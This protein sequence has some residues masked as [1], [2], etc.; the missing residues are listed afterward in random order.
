MTRRG[1]DVTVHCPV[2]GTEHR[3][4]GGFGT[5]AADEA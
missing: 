1:L 5:S 3:H 2:G 4:D